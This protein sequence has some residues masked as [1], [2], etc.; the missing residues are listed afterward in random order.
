MLGEREAAFVDAESEVRFA[1]M[2]PA[3]RATPSTSPFAAVPALTSA[4]VAGC[5]TTRASATATRS[6]SAL[7]ETSTICA[8]P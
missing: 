6:V 7:V 1:A 2:I 4:S 5:I 3:I 8:L